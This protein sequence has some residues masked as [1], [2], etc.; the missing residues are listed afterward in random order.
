MDREYRNVK[1]SKDLKKEGQPHFFQLHGSKGASLP[2]K[3][4]L[5][6]LL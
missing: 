3:I 1:F 4:I 5:F 6:C 2:F